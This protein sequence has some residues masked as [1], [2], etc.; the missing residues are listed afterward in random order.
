LSGSRRVGVFGGAFDPPH[1]AHV[2]L[3]QAAVEQ[4]GLDELRIL[5]TG[6]AWHKQRGLSDGGH[7]LAMAR[8]AFEVV[9]NAVVDERELRRPGATYTID[10]LRE[11]RAEQPAAEFFL[12]MGED[13]AASFTRWRD[14][15]SI[16]E[17]ATLCIA[18]RG[19]GA[20]ST[21]PPAVRVR[22]LA[23][24]RMPESATGIRERLTAGQDI[25]PLVPSGVAS[26][27]AQHLLYRNP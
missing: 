24:P 3:A 12:L 6:Q 27:I 2:A 25:A 17:L 22:R 19:E 21:L 8:L 7:R 1:R 4:L 14:W 5:P 15:A 11:L 18:Q 13:Q 23:L 20:A 26:Y 9:P 16:A 10:T